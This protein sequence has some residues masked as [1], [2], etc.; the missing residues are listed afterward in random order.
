MDLTRGLKPVRSPF[1]RLRRTAVYLGRTTFGHRSS[2]TVT[3]PGTASR[4]RI[5]WTSSDDWQAG[6]HRLR[7]GPGEAFAA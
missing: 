1:D 2:A 7:Q 6:C 4:R 5:S 3:I